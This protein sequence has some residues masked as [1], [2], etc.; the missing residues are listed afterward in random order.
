[1][2]LDLAAAATARARF[3]TAA[4]TSLVDTLTEVVFPVADADVPRNTETLAQSWQVLGPT[5]D[6]TGVSATL[7]YGRDDDN[8]PKSHQPSNAY[9]VAVHEEIGK[10]HPTGHSKWL[11]NAGTQ[12]AP[13]LAEEVGTRMRTRL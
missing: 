12:T 5:E 3:A 11:E 6:A 9:A 7:S 8:N 1:M 13:R 10:Q 4:G 2:P